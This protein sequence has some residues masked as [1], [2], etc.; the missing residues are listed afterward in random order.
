MSKE[1]YPAG[2]KLNIAEEAAT[3]LFHFKRNETEIRYYPTIKYQNMRIEFMFKGA[4]IVCNHPAWL[5]LDDTL[6]YFEKDIEGK[7]Y[8]HF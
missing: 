3:I 4:E 7:N 6:Y 2:R 1:G 5:L 8:S